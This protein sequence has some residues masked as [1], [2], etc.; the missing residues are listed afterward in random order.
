VPVPLRNKASR[1]SYNNELRLGVPRRS[2]NAHACHACTM[3]GIFT[4]ICNF[5][6]WGTHGKRIREKCLKS[7]S[8]FSWKYFQ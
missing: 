8:Q 4:F 5:A 3:G 7:I 1:R 2:T 6:L